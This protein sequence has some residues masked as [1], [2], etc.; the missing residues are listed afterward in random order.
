MGIFIMPELK[1]LLEKATEAEKFE[2]F[3]T[4]EEIGPIQIRALLE[5]LND[6]RYCKFKS[7]KVWKGRIGD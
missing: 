5:A 1:E 3:Q 2:E 6:I 4:K 7:L